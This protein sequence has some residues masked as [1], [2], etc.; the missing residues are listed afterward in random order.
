ME[1]K[2][3]TVEFGNVTLHVHEDHVKIAYEPFTV[4]NEAVFWLTPTSARELI[5][6]LESWLVERQE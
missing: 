3:I 4:G 6:Y 2:V 1:E 5:S